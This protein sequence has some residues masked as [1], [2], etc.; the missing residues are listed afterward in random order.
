M[1]RGRGGRVML[2]SIL[3]DTHRHAPTQKIL[4]IC[5]Q[6]MLL[7]LL[8]QG[9]VQLDDWHG[10]ARPRGRYASAGLEPGCL[11]RDGASGF[12]CLE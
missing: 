9:M 7:L 2:K 5:V 12:T 4:F 6:L 11:L 8:P 3:S 1:G 10:P